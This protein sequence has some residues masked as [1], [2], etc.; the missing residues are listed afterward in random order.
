MRRMR[1]AAALRNWGKDC[2]YP[3]TLLL[4]WEGAVKMLGTVD[5]FKLLNGAAAGLSEPRTISSREYLLSWASAQGSESALP[6][7]DH[8]GRCAVV[9]IR[10]RVA[11]KD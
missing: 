7:G 9:G 5:C 11:A 1:G 6:V 4:C 3:R 8:Y 2:F 10:R